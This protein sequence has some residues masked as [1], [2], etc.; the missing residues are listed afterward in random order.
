MFSMKRE[1]CGLCGGKLKDKSGVLQY[2]AQNPEGIDE[3]FSMAICSGCADD[4]DKEHAEG[5]AKELR[6]WLMRK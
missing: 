1:R 5:D 3:M 2:V 6:S 4:L